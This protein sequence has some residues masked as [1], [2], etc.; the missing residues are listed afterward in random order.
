MSRAKTQR[1]KGRAATRKPVATPPPEDEVDFT[2]P[3]DRIELDPLPQIVAE[4]RVPRRATSVARAISVGESIGEDQVLEVAD[5]ADVRA[6]QI[7]VHDAATHL[8][9]A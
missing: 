6:L 7:L 9:S 3:I 5:L 1:P 8:P 4:R 2:D